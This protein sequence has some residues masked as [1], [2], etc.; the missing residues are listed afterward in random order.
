M[1]NKFTYSDGNAIICYMEKLVNLLS[2]NFSINFLK[3]SP[4]INKDD[5]LP[6]EILNS[7]L[8]EPVRC[9]DDIFTATCWLCS[10]SGMYYIRSDSLINNDSLQYKFRL[11]EDVLTY[12]HRH[13]FV[14]LA[15]VVS[16][17]LKQNISGDDVV[18]N[19]GEI[20]LMDKYSYHHDHLY[21]DG[22]IIIFLSI[23]DS[24]INLTSHESENY[25]KNNINAFLHNVIIRNKEKYN[26]VRFTP[27]SDSGLEIPALLT[28]LFDELWNI[29]TGSKYM[30]QG[31]LER[32]LSL[33]PEEYNFSLSS[34]EKQ[35]IKLLLFNEISDFMNKNY[36]SISIKSLIEKF[37]YHE[38]YFNRL[39]KEFKGMTYSKYLQSIRLQKAFELLQTSRIPIVDI[40]N[41][42]GYNNI[43]YFYKIFYAEYSKTPGEFR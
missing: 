18:F 34:D 22:S 37:N 33:L 26:Y 40:A 36:G 2:D 16:G 29:R 30:I 6:T 5:K 32:I 10:E 24:I 12:S 43:G 35:Q 21:P 39:I 41:A 28:D 19:A 3:D 38:D 4:V 14:E 42:V 23:S 17:Q 8:A 27:K 20:C 1:I 25:A 13:N 9:L 15:F 7:K 11:D 31:I